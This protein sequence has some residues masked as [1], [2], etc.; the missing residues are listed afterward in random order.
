MTSNL[1]SVVWISHAIFWAT[2]R[3]ADL[4]LRIL[5]EGERELE[6]YDIEEEMSMRQQ[7]VSLTR[8]FIVKKWQ[9]LIKLALTKSMLY[10]KCAGIGM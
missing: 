9:I 6:V 2:E 5:E 4:K 8:I 7:G 10:Y 3:K 1:N